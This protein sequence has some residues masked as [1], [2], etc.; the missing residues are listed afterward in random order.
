MEFRV[1][2]FI[3]A[4]LSPAGIDLLPKEDL[5]ATTC[6]VF[7][8]L[9]ATSSMVTALAHGAGEILPVRTIK[10]AL[11]V[12]ERWPGAL[13]G[14]E[15][16]GNRID[17]FDLGNSPLEYQKPFERI[18]TT[19]TNGTVALRACAA[20]GSVLAGAFLNMAALVAWLREAAPKRLLM[21]CA[22]TFREL[23]LEDVI[24]AGMLAAAFPDAALSDAARVAVAA[25]RQHEADLPG[26]LRQSRNGRKL[27]EA[28]REEEL[29]W[30]AQVSHYCVVGVMRDGVIRA[31]PENM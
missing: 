10:E 13:L 7:D 29:V 11:A 15:R 30:C 25:F 24:A 1:W 19:T 23:A 4:V 5:S 18:I 22:G 28:G 16:N 31:I 12:R 8:V 27:I 3:D 26:A 9:R 2:M 17:G 6:V 14:G 21:V 20:A